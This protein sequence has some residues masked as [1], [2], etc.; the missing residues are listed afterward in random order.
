MSKTP[1]Y[2]NVSGVAGNPAPTA[3]RSCHPPAWALAVVFAIAGSLSLLAA[4]PPEQTTANLRV[5]A[6]VVKNC[7]VSTSD[8]AFG[9]YDPLGANRTA[10]VDQQGTITVRCTIGTSPQVSIQNDI[11][12]IMTGGGGNLNYQ[13]YQDANHTTP[14]TTT[15]LGGSVTVPGFATD[16]AQ[17]LNVYGRIPSGQNVTPGS[18]SH[19][20]T[21][22]LNF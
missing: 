5:T 9:T 18:Y 10:N 13:L 3:C 21:V 6:T 14:W 16:T 22:T 15:A 17:V 20:L 19:S 11:A 1:V 7:E 2:S 12:R 4:V 8:I